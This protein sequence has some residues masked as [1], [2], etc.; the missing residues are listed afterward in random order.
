MQTSTPRRWLSTL[1]LARFNWPNL[2]LVQTQISGINFVGTALV[3]SLIKYYIR[4][5]LVD[6]KHFEPKKHLS[7][8]AKIRII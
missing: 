1:E 2:N 6:R 8:F 4:A 5:T 7:F 3:I